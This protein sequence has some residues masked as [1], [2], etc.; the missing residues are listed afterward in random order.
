ML[1]TG[2]SV[3]D[4]KFR[5]SVYTYSILDSYSLKEDCRNNQVVTVSCGKC[6]DGV[7]Q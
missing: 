4:S 5:H 2:V 1:D 3:V 7:G 6:S